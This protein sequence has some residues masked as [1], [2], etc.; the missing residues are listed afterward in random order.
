MQKTILII[1]DNLKDQINGVV[2]TFNNIEIS[3]GRDGYSI[4]YI[5][6]SQFSYISAPGYPEVKIS[7][8]WGIGRKIQALKPDHVHIATEGPIGLA[9]RL[10]LDRR[11]WKYN[12]SYHTKFPEFINE[13]YHI[14]T[15]WTYAYV[16]WFHK[17][18]GRVLT[19]T[20]GMAEDLEQ[21][22]FKDVVPWTRGVNRDN[23][24][25]TV[26]RT[27]NR[28][29]VLLSVGR[30]SKE[31][32]LDD[33]I[34]LQWE[35]DIIIVGD[36]PY[37][38][39][40]QRRMPNAQFVGY[41]SGSELANYY[42]Q[43]DVFVF[44]SKADTFGLVMIESMSLGTPVAAYPVRG[45]LDVI[46]P[47]IT[48]IMDDNLYVAVNQA[49]KLDRSLVKTASQKWTWEECWQIFQKNLIDII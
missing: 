9:A 34:P 19:T 29:P 11:G 7:W 1:T 35:F 41:K 43:A 38:S 33:L 21:N 18:S 47:N 12:T 25:V 8:P 28:D 2:T 42:Q 39:E 36:G 15:V 20:K 48:G 16:R 5:D 27:I 23:L 31:K 4:V 45:P 44:P 3:A 46:D 13:I 24:S 40:L 26:D 17:H 32:G 14:P 22:G 37:R 49:M 30:V 10:W 6:P